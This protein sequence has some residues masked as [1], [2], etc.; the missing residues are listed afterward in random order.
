MRHVLKIAVAAGGALLM[1]L[2]PG[3]SFADKRVA[4]VVGNSAYQ[5]VPRLA[6][7]SNDANSVAK[8]FRDAKFD[9]VVVALDASQQDMRRKLQEFEG[10]AE[11]ADIAVLYYAGH[12]MEIGGDS[13]LIPTDAKLTAA[14]YI[15]DET[16]SLVR[17]MQSVDSVKRLR[18]II[19]DNCRDNPF[20]ASRQQRQAQRQILPSSGN[21][22]TPTLSNTMIA[23]AAAPGQT[24]DDG[25]GEHSPYTT[26]LLK[27]LT[28]PIDIRRVFGKVRDDVMQ[29]TNK[30]QEP[31]SSDSIGGEE[32]SLVPLP[33]KF[34]PARVKAEYEAAEKVGTR[35]AWESFLKNSPPGFYHDLAQEHVDEIARKEKLEAE[36]QAEK[37]R[38]QAEKERG[39][40]EAAQLWERIKNSN[41]PDD[42]RRF[43]ARFPQTPQ[44]AD[45]QGRLD[46]LA[47]QA[48]R[49]QMLR[50]AALAWRRIRN[51][52]STDELQNFI[53]AYPEAPQASEAKGRLDTIERNRQ[54][55]KE[56]GLREAAQA[57]EKIKTSDAPD[58][59]QRFID[60]YPQSP[61]LPDARA[62]LDDIKRTQQAE[63][64]RILR[65]AAQ[66]WEKIKTSNTR[67][68]FQRFIA[69]YPQSPLALDAKARLNDI[70]RQ[71]TMDAQFWQAERDRKLRDATQAWEKIKNSNV[72]EELDRFIA[73]Y[74]ESPRVS[75]ARARLDGIKR[76]QQAERE[77][78]QREAAQAWDRI[79]NS[80]SADDFERFINS[81]P[82][83][84]R[85]SDAQAQLDGIR[86]TQQAERE[87]WDQ[88]LRNAA[89]AW[90]KVRN[91]NVPDELQTFIAQ[92]P[93]SPQAPAARTRLDDV[94]RE[95]F[96]AERQKA[97]QAWD[98]VKNSNA[99]EDLR[100]FIARYPQSP[101]AANANARLNEITRQAEREQM[102]QKA[103]EAWEKVKSSNA[104]DELRGFRAAYPQS[105]QADYAAA[106]L[107]EIARQAGPKQTPREAA[108]AW[109]EIKKSNSQKALKSFIALY[110]DSPEASLAQ[111]RLDAIQRS[112]VKEGKPSRPTPTERTADEG[113][114]AG[115]RSGKGRNGLQ[116]L[117]QPIPAIPMIPRESGGGNTPL[118]GGVGF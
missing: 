61:R 21:R 93:Q 75:D 109:G 67:D 100:D 113:P 9:R 13:Y 73:L 11:N 28:E 85:A 51:P 44:A 83:S 96:A 25:N 35:R 32:M 103:A 88:M 7:P 63:R 49:D 71:A 104:P 80:K 41:A 94:K 50:N 82:Q 4:L 36:A 69:Q 45:A 24:A 60:S 65:E 102:L 92:Y 77:R 39:L 57:W 23:Y 97:I 53:A 43:I 26:A 106:R 62:R 1:A 56:R 38:A 5:N 47:R 16:I 115:T 116:Q 37:E 110:S 117:S 20:P 59:I 91:S 112:A 8:L 46:D 86:R 33:E 3:V 81:Y 99:A 31:W 42:F 55:E 74:P 52:N 30:R 89:Q 17:F 29:A 90:E 68:E 101:E 64:E 58:E 114:R 6:N 84:P 48:E 107:D 34:D 79:R 19:L 22:M 15:E 12:G 105:P 66:T 54:A 70:D 76:T 40:R 111:Q 118:H 78:I 27:H 2:A 14:R 18:V 98:R 10:E 87:K 95:Q 108:Q 72:P